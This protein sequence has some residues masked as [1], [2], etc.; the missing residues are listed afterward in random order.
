MFTWSEMDFFAM[1]INTISLDKLKLNIFLN[2]ELL[3]TVTAA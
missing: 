3:G 1:L 2:Y